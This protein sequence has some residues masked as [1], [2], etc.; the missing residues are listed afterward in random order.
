MTTY[1]I[2]DGRLVEKS[3]APGPRSAPYVISDEIPA[4]RHMA[5]N[6]YY[7]SKAKFR[8]ATKDAGC[9]EVGNDSS[10]YRPRKPVPLSRDKRRDDIRRTIYEL[11]NGIR[12]D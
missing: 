8:E 12:R 2:R 11:R 7:T 4:L 3:L 5:N 6:K 1:V 10:L 9:V